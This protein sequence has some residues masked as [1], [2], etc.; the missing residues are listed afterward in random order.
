MCHKD[1]FA[2]VGDVMVLQSSLANM[3]EQWQYKRH[4]PDLIALLIVYC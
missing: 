3:K 2:N 4:V 1:P